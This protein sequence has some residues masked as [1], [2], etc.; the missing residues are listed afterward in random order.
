VDGKNVTY[1][2]DNPE[3]SFLPLPIGKKDEGATT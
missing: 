2:E 1:Q 3:P